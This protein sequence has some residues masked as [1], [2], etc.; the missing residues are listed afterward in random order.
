MKLINFYLLISLISVLF[1]CN[2]T[3]D[4]DPKTT[5][6]SKTITAKWNVS[7]ITSP[8]K[9]IELNKSAQAIVL[10]RSGEY[11]SYS[12]KVINTRKFEIKDF[13]TIEFAD[14]TTSNTSGTFNPI[15][16][17]GQITFSATRKSE[18]VNASTNTQN[19]C[20]TWKLDKIDT[21]GV[22][23]FNSNAGLITVTFSEYGTYFVKGRLKNWGTDSI[24][25]DTNHVQMSW[26]NWRNSDQTEFCYDHDTIITTCAEQR[27]VKIISN[28]G[29]NAIWEESSN[30]GIVRIARYT[31]SAYTFGGRVAVDNLHPIKSS[32]IPKNSLFLK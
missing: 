10:K 20:K 18:I 24:K 21:N 3:K 32:G 4:N 15:A 5:L 31:M 19:I 2:D 11:K 25:V 12:Y 1:S 8:F 14:I 7:D 13:G 28:N 17:G 23:I 29:S 9:S 26:W 16:G 30:S 27:F 22:E 6:E